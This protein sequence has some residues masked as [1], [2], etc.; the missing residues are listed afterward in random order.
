L[1]SWNSF[2]DGAIYNPP[3]DFSLA[4]DFLIIVTVLLVGATDYVKLFPSGNKEF[5]VCETLF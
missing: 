1:V 2:S 5:S 3:I 4:G